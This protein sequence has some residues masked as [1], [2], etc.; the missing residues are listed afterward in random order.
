[1]TY[2][3]REE[4]L[5]KANDEHFAAR[6]EYVHQRYDIMSILTRGDFSGQRKGSR[7]TQADAKAANESAK[8]ERKVTIA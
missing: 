4:V 5:R 1:M 6:V 8:E 7:H 3:K 2:F